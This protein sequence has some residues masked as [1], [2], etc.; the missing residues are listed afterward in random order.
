MTGAGGP[1]DHPPPGGA[2]AGEPSSRRR[3]ARTRRRACAQRAV[4]AQPDQGCRD[5][6][7]QGKGERLVRQE[8]PAPAAIRIPA[9][10]PD[11]HGG[12]EDMAGG[13]QSANRRGQAA[14]SGPCPVRPAT[15]AAPGPALRQSARSPAPIPRATRTLTASSR[16]PTGL[17]ATD[18]SRRPLRSAPAG[19]GG[20]QRHEGR[21]GS[22]RTPRRSR[23]CPTA[24]AG[25][26]SIRACPCYN[27]SPT[28][29]ACAFA[30]RADCKRAA[31]RTCAI[32]PHLTPRTGP[33]PASGR[34]RLPR[35]AFSSPTRGT[36]RPTVFCAPSGRTPRA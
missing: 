28:A 32:L 29:A 2:Q 35:C 8:V 5:Q 4:V 34:R 22:R 30:D 13:S 9:P 6:E 16:R 11:V 7:R 17:R 10:E 1:R 21:A 12:E 26:I 31:E 27:A 19:D 20:G 25:S 24:R 33:R 14:A 18:S 36:A 3:T 23:P 15:K